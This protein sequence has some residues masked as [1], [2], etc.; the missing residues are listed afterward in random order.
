MNCLKKLRALWNS[1]KDEGRMII[2]GLTGSMAMGKSTAA[3][4]LANM[5]GVAVHDSDQAV[6]ALYNDG[7]VINRIRTAFPKSYDKKNNKI[8]KASLL[9]ALGSDPEKWD[10]L[11]AILHPFVQQAQQKFIR[12]QRALGTKIVVLDIPLLFETGAENRVDY[13][14]C[15][16]APDFVQQQRI[17][18]RIRDGFI[19]AEDAAWRMSRQM[20][21]AEKR[22]RA[23]FVVQTGQGMDY[24]RR[25]LE[26]II[27]DLKKGHLN[28]GNERRNLPPYRI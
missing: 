20:P 19:T 13:T 16:S 1:R 11:E 4:M 6:R 9:A 5:D 10:A 2:V 7:D 27:R 12:D 23:D 25:E 22:R 28:N 18:K 8:D 21:D 15:V 3:A 14:L 24:T 17:D 26:N